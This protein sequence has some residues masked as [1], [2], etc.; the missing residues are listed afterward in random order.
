MNDYDILNLVGIVFLGYFLFIL[1]M[2]WSVLTKKTR[3]FLVKAGV[4]SVLIYF[5]F[6]FITDSRA[7]AAESK[8]ESL[9]AEERIFITD[10]C[11]D[12]RWPGFGF[13]CQELFWV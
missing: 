12:I 1:K 6:R 9:A 5:S 3:S 10:S 11:L 7:T 13:N 8:M 2:V 4:V